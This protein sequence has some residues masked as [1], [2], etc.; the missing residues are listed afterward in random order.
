MKKMVATLAMFLFAGPAL[1]AAGPCQLSAQATFQS[2]EFGTRDAFW[3][4]VAICANDAPP[5]QRQACLG[6]A[7]EDE[8][9]AMVECR[10]QNES[11]L[12]VCEALGGGA[13][14]PVIDPANFVDRVDSAYF[15]L[16]PGDRKSV[17]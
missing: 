16:V 12:R 2:C 9:N 17:V 1:V 15:P 6:R 5:D 3:L 7:R 14:V 11:R 10:E 13:Y 4:A 8:K